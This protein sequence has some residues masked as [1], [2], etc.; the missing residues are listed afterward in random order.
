MRNGSSEIGTRE[1]FENWTVQM[2][3]GVLDLC[4]LRALSSEEWYG[5]SLVK[6]IAG[7]SGV[8]VAEGSI[9]PLLSRLKRQ[10]LVTTRLEESNEGPARK[11]YRA[12]AAGV[13]LAEEME[14][15]FG[16]M[17]RGVEGLRLEAERRAKVSKRESNEKSEL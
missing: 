16:E 4:I 15:Y 5:Y 6:A 3:K 8:G 14:R 9:Y 13:S 2:R 12:T 10:G 17:C 7:I 11:Y 1:W